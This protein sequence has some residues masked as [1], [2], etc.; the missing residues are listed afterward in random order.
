MRVWTDRGRMFLVGMVA[1][2]AFMVL[3]L[4][5]LVPSPYGFGG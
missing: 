1:L 2:I 4:L 3:A 5:I